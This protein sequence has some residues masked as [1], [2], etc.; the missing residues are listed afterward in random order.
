M[1]INCKYFNGYKPCIFQKRNKDLKCNNNCSFLEKDYKK[2]LVIKR[3]AIGEVMR[4]S[5]LLRKFNEEYNNPLI[6]WIT[7]YPEILPDLINLRKIKFTWEGYNYLKNIDFDIVYSLDKE[8]VCCMLS[9]EVNAFYRKGFDLK[10]GKIVPYDIDAEYLWKR[11]IDD[12]FMKKD[13]RHYLEEIFEVAG[14]KFNEE[15]YFLPNFVKI[16]NLNINK[17]KKVIGLNTGT[18]KTWKTR[19]WKKEN[20]IKLIN[21]LLNENYEVIL[22]GGKD[23]HNL[24]LELS[25][26]TNAK[27]FGYFSLREYLYLLNQ[28][29]LIVTQVTFA[30]HAAI[31]LKKKIILINNI[32]NKN[33]FYF[34]NLDYKIIEP[35]VSCLMCYKSNFDENC[36]VKN[37]MDLIIPENIFKAVKELCS[38]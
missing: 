9:K 24:N 31:G 35:S 6:Y 27:Y 15:E 25:N 18:S 16:N 7:D 37:C 32:F 28:V 33:E 22:L 10:D 21:L 14:F 20:W 36:E 5:A 4:C 12:E 2:I 38:K 30:M 11:G 29:D 13:I 3:G 26:K 19:L 17:N 23:E 8:N 1:E 34:Y